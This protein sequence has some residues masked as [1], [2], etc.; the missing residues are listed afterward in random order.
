MKPPDGSSNPA[1]SSTSFIRR[2]AFGVL[3]VN[4]FVIVLTGF[5]L[6]HGR[7]QDQNEAETTTR[8]LAQILEQYI[9]GAVGKIDLTLLTV[10]DEHARLA[11]AGGIDARVLNELLARQQAHLPEIISLRIADANGIVKYGPGVA[12]G[13]TV[14]LA[15]R[16]FFI[17]G[18]DTPHAGLIAAKPVFARIS[19]KWVIVLARRLNQPDGSFAGVVY[20]NLAVEHLSKTFSTI[21]VG[22]HGVISLR[23]GEL[24]L[25]AR[26]PEL[27][28]PGSAI[29]QKAVS[30]KLQE[31]VETGRP[32]GT[33]VAHAGTD[34]IERTFTFHKLSNPPYY[35]FVGLA[36]E[37]YLAE[38]R[39]STLKAS[40]LVALFILTTLI[41]SWLLY[42]AWQRQMAAVE[43]LTREENRF[44]TVA[45]YTYDWE[46]WQS[47]NRE[48]LY[49]TPSCERI[50]GYTHTE[51]ESNPALLVDIIHPEDRHLM[52]TH[53]DNATYHD[54][55]TVD[56]RIVRHDGEIC[57]IAHGCR[58]VYGQNGQFL[59]RRVSNRDIT[60]RKAVEEKVQTASLYAR[61]LI[62]ASLDPLVTISADGKIMDVNAATEKITGVT[63]EALIGSDFADYFT[64]PE[65]ARSGYRQVFEQGHT[66]D[67]P[68]AIRHPSGKVT[69]VLYNA[70]I[71]HNAKGEVAGVFAA[72]RDITARKQAE[73]A[74]KQLN[75][76]L[77][78]RVQEEV[79]KNLD[80]E[81]LLIQ[82]ARL[83]AMGEMIGNIAHQWRQPLNA[84]GLLLANLKDASDFH[85]LDSAT[86]DDTTTRGQQLIQKM[87]TTIDDFRNF[88]KPNK[89]KEDFS[90]AGAVGGTLNLIGHSL[91]NHNISVNLAAGENIRV[92]GYPNEFS[93]VLLNVFNNAKD[94]MLERR[95]KEGQ[96]EVTLG[97][98]GD[99]AWIVIGDNAGGIPEE[100]L[101]KIFD[102]YFTT[103][104]KGTGIGLYMSKMIMEHMNGVI[105]V[106]N[107]G[108]GAEF[109]LTL[110][111][112]AN[113]L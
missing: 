109:R 66:T 49:M 72:A 9:I 3:A 32:I 98:D 93:Q 80:Q 21:D 78:R 11:A 112:S 87:S 94:A 82:Q 41:A 46:Y 71:Y 34:N 14:N 61:S 76:T 4:L 2:L 30:K 60:E 57:W 45:D 92:N 35:I 113:A 38:W 106:R 55:A 85:E 107:S 110:P 39:N 20:A 77:D 17:R 79:A 6:I 18:R 53:L 62:E 47:P 81:R 43:A 91:K 52:D 19:K 42:R 50:T 70:S 86:I 13:S 44:R 33:Y 7:Q 40:G 74:L 5:W 104:E 12:P 1:I 24:G 22:K 105:E 96:I 95:I 75:A 63:R 37:D 69:E 90:L 23:D 111:R 29:G 51:F 36:T 89:L 101:P 16:E 48:I 88:F 103:K 54:E 100:V 15:D 84:L 25:I 64:E 99:T 108:S 8:N 26:H 102:P 68:L 28:E 58:A 56:F 65:K 73:E 97:Q 31:L 59:G 27:G 10:V 83:A 67:F